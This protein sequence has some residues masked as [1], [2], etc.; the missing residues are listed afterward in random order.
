MYSFIYEAVSGHEIPT[1]S[2]RV[3][4][5]VAEV[6][7]DRMRFLPAFEPLVLS[8]IPA[9]VRFSGDNEILACTG[10]VSTPLITLLIRCQFSF[11]SLRQ[12][13]ILITCISIGW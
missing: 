8:F 2:D 6:S 13:H 1:H 11:L 9:V 5:C 4:V 12:Y 3:A 10:R 7:F